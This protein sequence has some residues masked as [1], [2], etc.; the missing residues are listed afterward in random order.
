MNRLET[1]S[2][3]GAFVKRGGAAVLAVAF[4]L[5]AQTSSVHAYTLQGASGQT[6]PAYTS[7]GSISCSSGTVS[8]NPG[9]I[10]TRTPNDQSM[11]L[12]RYA[13]GQW[14]GSSW[15]EY[16]NKYDLEPANFSNKALSF[17][18]LPHGAAYTVTLLVY[19]YPTGV[20]NINNPA[21][22]SVFKATPFDFKSG[23]SV[24]NTVA[25]CIV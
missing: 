12:F 20:A 9:T 24:Y 21:G 8:I 22:V 17:Q 25:Y 16:D 18:N 15:P 7:G 19:F 2:T 4:V 13:L 6:V 23:A 3:K 11:V 14:N 10:Y 1:L 5:V